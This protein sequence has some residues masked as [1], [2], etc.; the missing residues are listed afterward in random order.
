MKVL[1]V[2]AIGL[3]IAMG[4]TYVVRQQQAQLVLMDED[5]PDTARYP[6]AITISGHEVAP[7]DDIAL[8]DGEGH[9]RRI[10]KDGASFDPSF[11][12]D[13]TQIAFTQGHGGWSD[14]TGWDEQGISIVDIDGSNR[15]A[16]TKG[17]LDSD[18]AWSPDGDVIAFARWGVGIMVMPAEG[19]KPRVVVDADAPGP[20]RPG[21]AERDRPHL[22]RWSADGDRIA[23]VAGGP[24]AGIY[25]VDEDGENLTEV[26]TKLGDA[27]LLAWSSENETFAYSGIFTVTADEP[28]PREFVDGV[29][30]DFSHD[31]RHLLYSD[32]S[33]LRAKPIEGGDAV[34]IDVDMPDRFSF[35]RGVDWLDCS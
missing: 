33:G 8:I 1:R 23:Y 27:D 35:G 15:R 22:P 14:S 4:I 34:T 25:V 20:E 24:E 5:C 13:G 18:P 9:L 2:A 19:G 3:I 32:R 31:G 17:P 6:L 16:A 28:N 11:S 21:V 29:L 12:P 30:G 10:T 7:N 26:A